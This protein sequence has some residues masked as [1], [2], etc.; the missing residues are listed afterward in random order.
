MLPTNSALDITKQPL[1]YLAQLALPLQS[2]PI[3]AFIQVEHRVP[4]SAPF[5]G[6]CSSN[7]K[8]VLCSFPNLIV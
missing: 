3:F 2:H 4:N 7:N 1:T 5:L 8:L 6:T